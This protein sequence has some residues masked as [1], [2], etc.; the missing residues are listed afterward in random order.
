MARNMLSW[1]KL[2]IKLLLLLL[3]GC[4]YYCVNIF[5]DTCHLRTW[6]LKKHWS[7][8][9]APCGADNWPKYLFYRVH[10]LYTQD[11]FHVTPPTIRCVVMR[12]PW[13][14][15]LCT[16]ITDPSLR[17]LLIQTQLDDPTTAPYCSTSEVVLVEE[18][19]LR[20]LALRV[21]K[22][23]DVIITCQTLPV[24]VRA[25]ELVTNDYTHVDKK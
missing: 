22:Q 8:N 2:L 25:Q 11:R 21:S 19:S 7:A 20:G 5:S 3:V 4:L 13:R 14:L 6:N 16:V 10:L 9:C 15:I 24:N 1:L 12:W 18:H 17:D 23:D